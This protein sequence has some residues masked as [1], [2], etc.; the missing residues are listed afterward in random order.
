MKKDSFPWILYH[1]GPPIL[2]IPLVLG[3]WAAL[4]YLAP[5]LLTSTLGFMVSLSV[6]CAIVNFLLAVSTK[7][8]GWYKPQQDPNK[9]RDPVRMGITPN[10]AALIAAWFIFPE[11]GIVH[12]WWL[13]AIMFLVVSAIGMAVFNGVVGRSPAESPAAPQA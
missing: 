10:Q 11:Q 3:P 13:Y 8:L 2:C 7:R 4:A 9:Q 12:P 5:G 6:V 1:M